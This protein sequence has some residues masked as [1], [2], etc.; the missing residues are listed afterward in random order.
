MERKTKNNIIQNITV[1]TVIFCCTIIP[2][3][4]GQGSFIPYNRDYYQLIERYE[5]KTG[6]QSLILNTG[7][8]PYRRDDVA[9][10]IHSI[11][12]TQNFNSSSDL[13]NFNYLK[14][15]NWEFFKRDTI[16]TKNLKIYS[17]A[18]DF[19]HFSDENSDFH[20]NPI[21]YLGYG[22][23]ANTTSAGLR[24]THGIEFRGRIKNEVSFYTQLTNNTL[25]F[26]NWINKRIEESD[27]IPGEGY[28]KR[29][30]KNGYSFFSALGH[31]NFNLSR[32]IHAQIGHD[33]NFVGEGYRSMILSDFS[34]PYF[35]T[36]IQTKIGKI[37]LTNLWAQ[38]TGDV[39]FDNQGRPK[40]GRY[41]Q[42]WFA[43]HRLS[44]PISTKVQLGLFES[45][46][47]N[48]FNINYVNPLIF[49]R[50][51]EHQLGSPDKIMIGT[52]FKYIPSPG[53]LLYG[54]F[55]LDEFVFKEFFGISGK[56]SSRN[57]YGLQAGL[58]MIDL[59]KISNL[60]VQL[61]Y[62][63]ARP[64]TYQEKFEYQAFSNYRNPLAHP[65]GANFREFLGIF[66][67][68]P[69]PR[70]NGN[71]TL[72]YQMY[73]DDPSSAINFGKSV[74][75]SRIDNN[76]GKGLFGHFIGQGIKNEVISTSLNLSYMVKHNLFLDLSQ[77][78]RIDD[79][80]KDISGANF[81]TQ[82]AVRLNMNRA[83]WNY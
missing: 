49:Y 79:N 20:I 2:E 25:I 27:A 15:D 39:L 69:L 55:A 11:Y 68:Q 78:F 17:Q 37:H 71:L 76:T 31:V 7:M 1:L 6:K 38:M 51:A 28:W 63:Q 83:D 18:S 4:Y 34:S 24:N 43:H 29:Y 74:L 62:N 22:N 67:Y 65:L 57:K 14:Q 13:F 73:G 16:Q 52:D 47:M 56:Q 46:M 82:A 81:F 50:W 59:L 44:F 21:L 60:D 23:Q 33:R 72:L 66:R 10:F 3:S 64:Y 61:E 26:P 80:L 77:T 58:K 36:K 30:N 5:I 12:T 40:D 45:I 9:E 32:Y 70:L 35:F 41:P 54:Q 8:K 42:K 75:K 53:F 19:Y 48:R